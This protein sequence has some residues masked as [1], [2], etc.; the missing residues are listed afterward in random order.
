MTTSIFQLPLKSL[1]FAVHICVVGIN[2][3]LKGATR[4]Y[5][6]KGFHE[7]LLNIPKLIHP[8]SLSS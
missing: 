2:I 1:L 6:S 8:F 4:I 7:D 3:L 5:Y